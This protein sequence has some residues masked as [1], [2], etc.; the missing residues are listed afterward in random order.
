[1]AELPPVRG[2][3][4]AIFTTS[5]AMAGVDRTARPTQVYSMALARAVSLLRIAIP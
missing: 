1:M 3:T 2:P 5:L 4:N